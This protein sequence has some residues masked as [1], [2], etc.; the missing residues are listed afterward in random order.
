VS[1]QPDIGRVGQAGPPGPVVVIGGGGHAKVVIDVLLLS[2][3]TVA[4]YTDPVPAA[5]ERIA[6]IPWLG[7]DE[8][9]PRLR[10]DGIAWAIAA[11][12]DNALRSRMAQHALRLG[13]AL[14]SAVHPSAQ[15]SP[16]AR[17][18]R[19]VAIMPAVA[20]NAGSVIGDNAVLN[21]SSSVDHDCLL[22]ASVHVAPGAHLAGYITLEDEVLVG[23]GAIVGRGRPILVGRGAVVGAGA[24]VI[25]DVAPGTTVAGNPARVLR[26]RRPAQ[27]A[28]DPS[29][30]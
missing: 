21:T 29:A 16:H 1:A 28:G 4:G 3:W 22:G 26:P 6:G 20:V 13:F 9:L 27:A 8:V 18:G 14:A 10:A 25:N 2:G 17:L 15:V 5:G 24:V 30:A 7:T 12:G 11:F 19:G 23:G